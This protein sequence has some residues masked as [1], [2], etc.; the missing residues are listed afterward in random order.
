MRGRGREREKRLG[1][2]ENTLEYVEGVSI[3]LNINERE[4]IIL[5]KST[6]WLFLL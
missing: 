5:E 4:G 6:H 2:A 1:D 3:R